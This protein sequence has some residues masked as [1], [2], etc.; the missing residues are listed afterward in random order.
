MQAKAYRYVECCNQGNI[1]TYEAS[2][3]LGF[4]LWSVIQDYQTRLA[5]FGMKCSS[6]ATC[7]YG[8]SHSYEYKYRIALFEPSPIRYNGAPKVTNKQ[9]PNEDPNAM[10]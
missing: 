6:I 7:R 9:R 2:L 1:V 8:S 10:S 3:E 4:G 5:I